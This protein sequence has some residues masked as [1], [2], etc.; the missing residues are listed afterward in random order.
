VHGADAVAEEI[1]A[2]ATPFAP[3]AQPAMVNG[4]PGALVRSGGRVI[5]VTNV[6]VSDGLITEI[7]IVFDRAKLRNVRLG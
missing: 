5:A 4:V 1:V 3:L 7:D 6:V 2:R